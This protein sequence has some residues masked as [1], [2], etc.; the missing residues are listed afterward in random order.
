MHQQE[1]AHGH[2]RNAD[3]E[4]GY[5]ARYDTGGGEGARDEEHKDRQDGRGNQHSEHADHQLKERLA[6]TVGEPKAQ[7]K[8]DHAKRQGEPPPGVEECF[9]DALRFHIR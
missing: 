6:L 5:E 2:G 1:F 8:N 4:A 7:A 3:R 9:L